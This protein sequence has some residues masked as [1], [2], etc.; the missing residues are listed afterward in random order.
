[1]PAATEPIGPMPIGPMPRHGA[2]IADDVARHLKRL[3]VTGAF[4]NGGR[5]PAERALAAE[6]GVSRAALREA[7]Q[8]LQSAGLVHSQQ[9]SGTRVTHDPSSS[10]RLVAHLSQEERD[11]A[12]SAELR[13][14]VEPQIARLAAKRA[15]PSTVTEMRRIL[16]SSAAE[17]DVEA[18]MS[19]DIEFHL[20]V[21]ET[22][23]NSLLSSLS[24]LTA[25]WTISE[26]AY[27]HLQPRG[28]DVSRR[29]HARILAAIESGDADAAERAMA[30]HLE[31]IG[32]VIAEARASALDEPE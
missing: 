7:L 3:I 15:T 8:Q 24:G 11:F 2:S 20:A 18:S 4:P 6:L 26:R 30:V 21:A 22:A 14:V 29:G 28:R 27:S 17:L 12:E 16:D 5:L 32:L 25:S 9:G 10:A 1:M 23:G 31:E 13:A 19:L